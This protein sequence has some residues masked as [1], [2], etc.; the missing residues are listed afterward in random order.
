VDGGEVTRRAE[1]LGSSD[2]THVARFYRA[3]DVLQ[4]IGQSQRERPSCRAKYDALLRALKV[5]GR[6]RAEFDAIVYDRERE[7]PLMRQA[8]DWIYQM[9]IE[10][11]RCASRFR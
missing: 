2:E 7:V 5:F 8:E 6:L 11:D 3:F 4:D 10:F 9:T 1:G